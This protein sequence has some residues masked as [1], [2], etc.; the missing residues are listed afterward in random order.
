MTTNTDTTLC[1]SCG[2]HAADQLVCPGCG[3]FQPVE[4]GVDFFTLFSLPRRLS[5]DLEDLE[6]RYYQLSRRLHPDVFH[7]HSAAERVASLRATAIVN[8]AYRILK[9]PVQRGL[10]WL[11]LHGESLGRDNHKVAP[12]L[13]SLVF[14]VQERIEELRRAHRN[15]GG[16]GEEEQLRAIR[17]RL[18]EQMGGILE[19]LHLEFER[20]DQTAGEG[21]VSLAESKSILSELHYLRTLIRD[22][23]KELEPEWNA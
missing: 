6:R 4:Q 17:S 16:G 22:V 8:R 5:I 23:D 18:R 13:A 2:K 19:R 11:S 7:D 3:V 10:Y 12:E 9:D 20:T 1:I 21:P 15:G 14:D